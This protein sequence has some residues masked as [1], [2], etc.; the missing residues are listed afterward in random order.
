MNR[1]RLFAIILRIVS[2]MLMSAIFAVVLPREMMNTIHEALGLGPLPQGLIVDYLA[3]TLSLFYALHGAV[4][5]YLSLKPER[6]VQFLR[7]YLWLSGCFA[8]TVLLIDIAIGM[9][10]Q[11]I[12]CEGPFALVLV[13]ILLFLLKEE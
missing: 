13:T 4:L 5:F 9:P 3:R 6:Y 2:I 12:L 7:F 11:W 1:M 8:L 10:L